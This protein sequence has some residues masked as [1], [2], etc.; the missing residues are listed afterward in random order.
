MAVSLVDGALVVTLEPGGW[1]RL[2]GRSTLTRR[3]FICW[4]IDDQQL[5]MDGSQAAVP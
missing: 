3:W 1:G 5:L 4:L 2:R